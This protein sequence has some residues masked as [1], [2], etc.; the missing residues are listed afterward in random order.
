MRRVLWFLAA[1]AGG[2]V[3]DVG[4]L[5]LL[6]PTLGLYF[7]RAASFLAAASFTWLV[8]RKRAFAGL[9]AGTGVGAEYLRY[10][11]L[12]LGGGALN[13]TVYALLVSFLPGDPLTLALCVAAGTVAGVAANYL[14]ARRW[15]Y[16]HPAR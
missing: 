6:Q 3:V 9:S 2:F 14:G 12:M 16:S 7:A 4:V 15:L 1:G 10:L 5:L 13:Y 8:N 11:L